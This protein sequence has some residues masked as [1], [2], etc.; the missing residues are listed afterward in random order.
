MKAPSPACSQRERV[1]YDLYG[2][3]RSDFSFYL[4]ACPYVTHRRRRQ[5]LESTLLQYDGAHMF[6]IRDVPMQVDPF[7]RCM[8][9]T[10]SRDRFKEAPRGG[11][12][13]S[14]PSA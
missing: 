5:F 7:H 4:H 11:E 8:Y 6:E 3:D 13:G 10:A 1:P 12:A 2:R 9:A 14:L